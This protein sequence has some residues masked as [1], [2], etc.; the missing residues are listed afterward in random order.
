M[1]EYSPQADVWRVVSELEKDAY[2][3][4]EIAEALVEVAEEV[5]PTVDR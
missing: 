4:S 2:T 3:R 1:S 5:R